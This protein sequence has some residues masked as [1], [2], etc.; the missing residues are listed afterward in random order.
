MIPPPYMVNLQWPISA[1]LTCYNPTSRESSLTPNY[2][3]GCIYRCV[4]MYTLWHTHIYI[5]TLIHIF[6]IL[7][8][9][10]LVGPHCF[11]FL[12]PGASEVSVWGPRGP[13]HHCCGAC[14]GNLWQLCSSH[15]RNVRDSLCHWHNRW[16]TVAELSEYGG[17]L[18]FLLSNLL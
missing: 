11:R 6:I 2:T 12:S 16:K 5:Y 17:C 4:Y 13:N 7:T 9:I 1:R 3:G 15:A 18:I 8:C 10:Q 14:F